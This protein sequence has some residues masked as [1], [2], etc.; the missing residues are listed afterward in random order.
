[1]S[2]LNDSCYRI[3]H[4]VN[5]GRRCALTLNLTLRMNIW[6]LLMF[7]KLVLYSNRAPSVVR[8]TL[9]LFNQGMSILKFCSKNVFR[10]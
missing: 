5:I 10:R 2:R 1:M 8:H 7:V 6:L 4:M 9:Y 3:D